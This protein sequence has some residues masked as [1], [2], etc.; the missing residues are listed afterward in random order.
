MR[1]LY[2]AI[3]SVANLL[4]RT[5]RKGSWLWN[6]LRGVRD[7]IGSLRKNPINRRRWKRRYHRFEGIIERYSEETEDFFV[8]QVGACDGVMGDPI[9]KWIKQYNWHGIL[10]EPQKK[11]FERLTINY[12]DSDRLRFENVAIAETGGLRPL[13]KVKDEKIEADWQRGLASLVA[14]PAVAKQDMITTEMVPCITF[15]TLLNQHHVERI[16]LLQIDVE[17]YDYELLKLFDFGRM[18]PRL[19][20]YEH[21]H[22][23]PSDKSFCRMHLQREGYEILEMEYD[24]GAVLRRG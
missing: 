18:R 11:E 12:R 14:R 2:L 23:R 9:Q 1:S 6:S 16:D 20:R 22:L 15:N 13:Y 19:I 4:R 17:G 24:T 5:V 8:L 3:E 21:R 7:A 10:V